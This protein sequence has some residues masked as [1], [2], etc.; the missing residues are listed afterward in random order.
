MKKI[1]LLTSLTAF[2]V[3]STI[4]R[5]NAQPHSGQQSGGGGVSGGRIGDAPSGAPVGSGNLLLIGLALLYATKKA[6]AS[7]RQQAELQDMD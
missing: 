4:I 2:L 3:F 1:I 6:A 5:V 7:R